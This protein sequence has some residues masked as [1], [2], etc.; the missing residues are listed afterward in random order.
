M[1]ISQRKMSLIVNNRWLTDESLSFQIG[2]DC[3]KRPHEVFETVFLNLGAEV[4]KDWKYIY[5]ANPRNQQNFIQL[6]VAAI[7]IDKWLMRLFNFTEIDRVR[8]LGNRLA[9]IV[10]KYKNSFGEND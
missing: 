3:C 10:Y 1:K 7:L 9:D 4:G 5:N 2:L 8:L 6:C